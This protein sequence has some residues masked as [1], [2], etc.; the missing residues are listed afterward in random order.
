MQERS[1]KVLSRK[2]PIF[3]ISGRCEELRRSCKE[4][5]TLQKENEAMQEL[6]RGFRSWSQI[7]YYKSQSHYLKE[8]YFKGFFLIFHKFYYYEE[9]MYWV[10]LA[11]RPAIP[12]YTEEFLAWILY[13]GVGF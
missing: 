3:H 4:G 10:A 5:G 9:I 7:L 2:V 6:W 8:S 13:W 12:M 1:I 11:S